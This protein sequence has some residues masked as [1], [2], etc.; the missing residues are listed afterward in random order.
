MD[1]RGT[2]MVRRRA[3]V[4]RSLAVLTVAALALVAG[5]GEESGDGGDASNEESSTVTVFW[6]NGDGKLSPTEVEVS[7]ADQMRPQ[8]R[9]LAALEEL[10]Q[11]T[12]DE[13]GLRSHWGGRCAV[14]AKVDSLTP[15]SSRVTVRVRG[16]AG[17]MCSRKGANLEQQRQQLA[18][19]VVENLETDPSTPVRLYGSN[20]APMW[21][22]VVA[23]EKILAE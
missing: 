13:D 21:G 15:E 4:R 12:P 16:A 18:W 11:T 10:V 7:G 5:C 20:G 19:T 17:V 2:S 14:G 6:V 23:D 3:T 22:D 8:G 1:Q 9:A